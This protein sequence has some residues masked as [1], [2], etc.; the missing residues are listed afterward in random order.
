MAFTEQKTWTAGDLLH[1][2]DGCHYELVKGRLVQMAP[3]TADHGE[4]SNDLDVEFGL[5]A[6]SHGGHAYAAETGFNVTYPGEAKETVLAPDASYIADAIVPRD[7]HGFVGRAPDV[8]VEVASP[9]QWQPEMADKARLWLARGCR[10][11]W[12][13]WP[14]YRRVDVWRPGDQEPGEKLHQGDDLMGGDVMPG[15]QYA[16]SKVLAALD[17]SEGENAD[18]AGGFDR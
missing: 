8:A 1:L 10:L 9:T 11:V 12:V 13:V 2:P 18:S 5:Y 6:R 7:A 4:T 16:V 15:F 17:P 14:R 3:A